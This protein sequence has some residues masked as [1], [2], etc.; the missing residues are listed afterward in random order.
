MIATQNSAPNA[1]IASNASLA[2]A[3]FPNHC[4][5]AN[6]VGLTQASSDASASQNN[7]QGTRS[8]IRRKS[9]EVCFAGSR[10]SPFAAHVLGNKEAKESAGLGSRSSS[11]KLN[12]NR[13]N[14]G[15]QD[16]CH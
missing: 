7:E 5:I 6:N 3:S 12:E 9:A 2:T 16:L 11:M 8:S 14:I 1:V 10:R 15:A 13:F 4:L